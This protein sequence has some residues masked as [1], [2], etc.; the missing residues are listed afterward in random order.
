MALA[1]EAEKKIELEDIE[2]DN[3][4]SELKSEL[5]KDHD[6]SDAQQNSAPVEGQ[7]FNS[8]DFMKNGLLRFFENSEIQSIH[9]Q[10]QQQRYLHQY[11]VTEPP[12][13]YSTAGSTSQYVPQPQQAM[14]GYLSNMPMQI[15]LV[16]QFYST[17]VAPTAAPVLAEFNQNGLHGAG[18]ANNYIEAPAYSPP[19]ASPPTFVYRAQPT[20]APALATAQPVITYQP[21][22]VPFL[23]YNSHV[24]GI[25]LV[26][27]TAS[28]SYYGNK[29][30]SE[31][32][33]IDD[34]TNQSETPPKYH[35]PSEATFPRHYN[36]RAPFRGHQYKHHDVPDLPHPSPLILKGPPAHLSHIPRALPMQR[37]YTKQVYQESDLTSSSLSPR[38]YFSLG[39]F[40]RRPTSL[41]DSYIPSSLQVEYLKRGL[42]KDPASLYDAL[43]SGRLPHLAIPRHVEKGFLPNQMYPTAAGGVTY[44]HYKRNP[45]IEKFPYK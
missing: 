4:R 11:A 39:Q 31:T 36:S 41:L 45:K 40:K 16:P 17:P 21:Y 20:A 9:P 14:V 19:T 28:K 43:S 23:N 25:Q 24:P 8:L 18:S 5:E 13:R 44:G 15:Y 33:L 22:Q 37:P 1:V 7:G 30:Y 2:E 12:E 35:P 34:D 10:Q 3:L 32:N 42:A 6:K 29:D 38:P 27:S 26:P